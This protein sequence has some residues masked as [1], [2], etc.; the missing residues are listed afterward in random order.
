MC[1]SA[2]IGLLRVLLIFSLIPVWAARVSAGA[3]ELDEAAVFCTYYSLSG[4]QP[5]DRDIEDFCWNIGKPT[6][7]AFKPAEMFS[8]RGLREARRS[9]RD[10]MQGIGPETVFRWG[11][12]EMVVE[13]SGGGFSFRPGVSRKDLPHATSFIQAEISP[14]GW[15][16]LQRA[17][18]RL[19]ASPGLK[20]TPG[21]GILL[22]PRQVE[23][24][25]ERRNI[26]FEEVRIPI[27][28]VVFQ[29]VAVETRKGTGRATISISP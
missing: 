19:P 12:E 17:L 13:G 4:E 11:A 2:H 10:L 20:E 28:T 18:K 25:M 24:R 22:Q 14:G 15:K 27:R 7:S 23:D 29:P 8:R 21:L 5:E 6:F 9:L 26:A 16:R 3:P 1:H